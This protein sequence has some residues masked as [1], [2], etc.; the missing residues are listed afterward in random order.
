MNCEDAIIIPVLKARIASGTFAV[1]CIGNKD[2]KHVMKITSVSSNGAI[3]TDACLPCAEEILKSTH[4]QQINIKDANEICQSKQ[5]AS[6]K[7]KDIADIAHA[8]KRDIESGATMSTND[9]SNFSSFDSR[10]LIETM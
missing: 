1:R 10:S 2:N 6:V 9:I 5:H 8:M 3:D 7:A 4:Q